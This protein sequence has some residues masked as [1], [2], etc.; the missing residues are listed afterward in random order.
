MGGV[1]KAL[2]SLRKVQYNFGVWF[3]EVERY[4]GA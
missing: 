1:M 4:E 3:V 2:E